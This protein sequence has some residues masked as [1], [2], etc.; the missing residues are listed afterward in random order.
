[1]CVCMTDLN[2]FLL[3]PSVYVLRLVVPTLCPLKMILL[4]REFPTLPLGNK[5]SSFGH[6]NMGFRGCGV[7]HLLC[8]FL[9]TIILN[10]IIPFHPSVS[11]HHCSL[12]DPLFI[13]LIY[14]FLRLYYHLRVPV[15][16]CGLPELTCTQS[17][18]LRLDYASDTLPQFCL[19]IS[20]LSLYSLAGVS[21]LYS[22]SVTCGLSPDY[23][24]FL[25]SP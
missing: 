20:S 17:R 1:M 16:L 5:I 11:E 7:I 12:P 8:S 24:P 19:I 3:R 6:R 21:F 25:S 9:F 23:I 13:I 15:P 4:F 22:L 18:F 10:S 2:H 14:L